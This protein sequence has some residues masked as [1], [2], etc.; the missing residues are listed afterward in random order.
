MISRSV[1]NS[2]NSNGLKIA[3]LPAQICLSRCCIMRI[4][5]GWDTRFEIRRLATAPAQQKQHSVRV[6]RNCCLY[7][8]QHHASSHP[9][10]GLFLSSW[11]PSRWVYAWCNSERGRFEQV[12]K[13]FSGRYDE[14]CEPATEVLL[15]E[16]FTLRLIVIW[17]GYVHS[18]WIFWRS[19]YDGL[20]W[21]SQPW[22][23]L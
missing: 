20:I 12:N 9:D 13:R 16:L 11:Y 22:L 8:N 18:S 6:G 17:R 14:I 21:A 1:N 7:A 23:F 10:R 4:P 3:R 15:S 2:L 5:N 19:Q